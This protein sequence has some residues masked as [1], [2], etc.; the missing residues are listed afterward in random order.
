MATKQ[1]QSTVTHR[2][3]E[4]AQ[5]YLDALAARDFDRARAWLSSKRFYARSPISEYGSADAFIES[6]SRIGPILEKLECRK[7]FVDG[8]EVC[9]IVDYVTRM[10]QRL[11][12]PVVHWLRI[13]GSEI[14][15]IES[16][17]DAH[18]YV[19]MFSVE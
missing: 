6:V 9:L 14:V 12:S 15:F 17:F 3:L 5:A 19:S 10:D 11:I 2:P 18:G 13:E 4:V 8:N 7:T 16:F 1:M